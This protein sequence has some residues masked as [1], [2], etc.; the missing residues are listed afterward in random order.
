MHSF[1]DPYLWFIS[2]GGRLYRL[3]MPM[4]MA[5]IRLERDG[6]YSADEGRGIRFQDSGTGMIRWWM[7]LTQEINHETN[8]YMPADAWTG[9]ENKVVSSGSATW[10]LYLPTMEVFLLYQP[11]G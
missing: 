9:G 11:E 10:T 7:R 2:T 4:G 5:N 6:V 1:D 8:L 3:P